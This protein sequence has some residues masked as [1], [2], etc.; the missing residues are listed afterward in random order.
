VLASQICS[1]KP[2]YFNVLGTGGY[3]VPMPGVP[4]LTQADL[5][6]ALNATG[7]GG[8][9]TLPEMTLVQLSSP[10]V[11]PAGVT[12][13]TA[14]SPPVS[15][16]GK[17]ARLVRGPGYSGGQAMIKLLGGARLKNI[18]VDGQRGAAPAAGGLP[19][20]FVHG[21]INIQALSGS[22]TEIA[23][24]FIANT[25]GWSSLQAFGQ[26]ETGVACQ[27]NSITGNTITVYASS[28]A[29]TWADG[30]SDSCEDSVV[31]RNQIVDATDGGI[32]LF[33]AQVGSVGAIQRSQ[34]TDNIIINA[35]NSAYV[36]IAVDP[37]YV[38]GGCSTRP[39][40]AGSYVGRN[41]FWTGPSAIIEIGLAV[42]TAEWFFSSGGCTGTGAN[43]S[44]NNTN[45]FRARVNDGIA[46][47]GMLNATVQSNSLLTTRV[48]KGNCASY[49]VSAGVSAGIASGSIQPYV[50]AALKDCI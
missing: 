41:S 3:A 19:Q 10:L 14:G 2:Y 5:Q 15:A 42:G 7:P 32:V 38:P 49:D 24:N 33:R 22:G 35:G 1:G 44:N 36:A 21:E 26:Y 37:L 20:P 23:S 40:F 28:N 4:A 48:R 47:Q 29:D 25:A 39:S 9:V 6:G 13:T 16:H 34:V 27:A 18:W 45:G 30:I 17:M 8:T 46:V 43:V 31:S 50:N 12:L 11:V